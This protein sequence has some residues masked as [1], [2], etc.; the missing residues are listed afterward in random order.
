MTGRAA[1]GRSRR[2]AEILKG[3]AHPVRIAIA[4]MLE[5]KELC[6]CEIADRF[7]CD[8]TTTSKHLAV[9]R[10]LGILEDRREGQNVCY[11]L[12]MV[13]LVRALRCIDG[14]IGACPNSGEE[15]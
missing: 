15:A 13:C 10:Q 1:D 11:R 6:A 14:L 5:D 8:R 4:E 12:K 9:M 2:K 3:L 7:P